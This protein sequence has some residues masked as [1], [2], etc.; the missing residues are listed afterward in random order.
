MNEKAVCAVMLGVIVIGVGYF[1]GL[2]GMKFVRCPEY[3][4]GPAVTVNSM[5]TTVTTTPTPVAV[6]VKSRNETVQSVMNTT[7]ETDSE[8]EPEIITA[9]DIGFVV[10]T[11]YY[12]RPFLHLRAESEVPRETIFIK[13]TE[14]NDMRDLDRGG[15][16]VITDTNG[17]IFLDNQFQQ[18]KD[19]NRLRLEFFYKGNKIA[20][21]TS[22]YVEEGKAGFAPV[23]LT[24]KDLSKWQIRII[25]QKYYDMWLTFDGE[26]NIPDDQTIIAKIDRVVNDYPIRE[27]R[28]VGCAQHIK[29][30]PDCHGEINI[31]KERRNSIS[32]PLGEGHYKIM[33]SY[34]DREYILGF[35]VIKEQISEDKSVFKGIHWI[36]NIY[37]PA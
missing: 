20:S 35:E 5:P 18:V 9:K 8:P 33:I 1:G 21:A 31:G 4:T 36:K 14:I 25:S 17:M 32:V 2:V 23:L 15:I 28:D 30:M 26:T 24:T 3:A 10:T 11:L 22:A 34:E 6:I 12:E 13:I 27:I 19:G 16:G 37:V 29:I 7:L